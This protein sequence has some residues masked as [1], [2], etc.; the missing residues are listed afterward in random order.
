MKERGFES[1]ASIEELNKQYD[2]VYISNVLEHI[3]D[4][5]AVLKQ[6][7][8]VLK[9]DGKVVIYSPAFQ[10]LYTSFD[11]QVGHYRRYSLGDLRKKLTQANYTILHYEFV[12]SLG[13]FAWMFLK[14]NKIFQIT[15]A[16]QANRGSHKSFIIYDRYFYPISKLLDSIGLKYVMGK[17]ILIVAKKFITIQDR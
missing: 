7:Q 9:E 2:Q 4:D 8:S 15:K 12:D 14:F 3:E 13:F 10:I 5:V 11:A 17:N 1:S 6:I 16:S